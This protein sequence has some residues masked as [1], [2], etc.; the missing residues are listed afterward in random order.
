MS[1]AAD[2]AILDHLLDASSSPPA[3]APDVAAWRRVWAGIA[4]RWETPC[5]RAIAGGTAADRPAWA[6]AAGYQAALQRLWPPADPATLAAFCVTEEGGVHP[7]AI[8][9]ALTPDPAEPGG[10][11]LTGEKTFVTGAGEAECLLVAAVCGATPEGR[12]ILRL[13]RVDARAPG[14]AVTPLPPLGLV[15]E[16][17]HGR[18]RFTGVALEAGDLLPGDG[19]LEAVKP[20]RTVEDLH[21]TAALIAWVFAAGR[22]A[23]WP[24]A[25]LEPLLALLAS[26][27][28]LAAAPP[29]APHVHL[30]LAGLLALAGE[31]LERLEPL[32]ETA[33]PTDRERWQRDR[34]LLAIAG[35]ARTRRLETA[36]AHYRR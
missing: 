27:R 17:P 9:C 12:R 3:H 24:P 26:A 23:A 4:P 34:G 16:L 8:R 15:P 25:V 28:G 11:R 18:V 13:A 33:A 10:W 6:F 29:L 21:V 2:L 32:W 36:R 30:T 31:T 22:R 19:Y 7:A 20:F 1:P 5:D 14:V 35:A